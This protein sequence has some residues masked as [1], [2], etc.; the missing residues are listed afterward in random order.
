MSLR[1]TG[2]WGVVVV[3]LASKLGLR[4]DLA[5]FC[6]GFVGFGPYFWVWLGFGPYFEGFGLGLR[7]GGALCR[8]CFLKG[9][10]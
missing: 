3:D 1:R 10:L 6:A 9:A 7:R 4:L 2:D 8:C 5:G